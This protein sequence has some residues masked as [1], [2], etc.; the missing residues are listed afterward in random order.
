M[1]REIFLLTALVVIVI[2]FALYKRF[3]SKRYIERLNKERNEREKKRKEGYAAL[4][5]EEKEALKSMAMKERTLFIDEADKQYDITFH[6]FP[7]FE[8]IPPDI[9]SDDLITKSIGYYIIPKGYDRIAAFFF[10]SGEVL[11]QISAITL[12]IN[13]MINRRFEGYSEFMTARYFDVRSGDII[14]IELEFSANGH[15]LLENFGVLL[16]KKKRAE[17][18]PNA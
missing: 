6:P 14:T 2:L 16:L 15:I 18:E 12:N 8:Y 3:S 1:L 11:D 17:E 4:S 10:T 7:P 5:E 13:G 9:T